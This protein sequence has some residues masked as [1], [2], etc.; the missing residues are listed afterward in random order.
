MD[1]LD[2]EMRNVIKNYGTQIFTDKLFPLR[3]AAEQAMQQSLRKQLSFFSP[4]AMAL[5]GFKI[6]VHLRKSAF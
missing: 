4:K 3:L 1:I 5:I 2:F 6:C